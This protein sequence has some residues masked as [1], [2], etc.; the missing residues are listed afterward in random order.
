RRRGWREQSGREGPWGTSGSEPGFSRPR[1]GPHAGW[2]QGGGLTLRVDCPDNEAP[3]LT[4]LLPAA[5][6]YEREA[7]DMLGVRFD[8]HANLAPLL[9]AHEWTGPP[10]LAAQEATDG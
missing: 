2:P 4:P 6:W 9:L 1:T 7:H 8:G 3:S 5:N 10:P